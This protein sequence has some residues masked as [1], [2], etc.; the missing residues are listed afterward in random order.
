MDQRRKERGRPALTRNFR[1]QH[2]LHGNLK[3]EEED[4]VRGLETSTPSHWLY[5]LTEF[6]GR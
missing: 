2:K 5:V 6:L 1:N 3:D 4:E